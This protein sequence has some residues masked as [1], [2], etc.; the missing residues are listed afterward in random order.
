VL[1]Q[2]RHAKFDEQLLA[3]LGAFLPA[4]IPL[5]LLQSPIFGAD[6]A[7]LYTRKT[8]SSAGKSRASEASPRRLHLIEVRTISR[9]ML[10]VLGASALFGL[11]RSAR[12]EQFV[13]VDAT[14]DYTWDDAMNAKPNKSHFYVNDQNFLNT[15][16]PKNWLAPV[17]Y[18][19]GTLHV[20]TEV[21]K[22]PAGDQQVG[23]TLCYIA[24]VGDYGCADTTYYKTTG[25]FDRETKMTDWW[26][27]DKITWD[28]G[29]K[30]VDLIYAINDSGSGHITNYPELKDLTTPTRVRI[31]MVQVS[32]GSA[33]DP[34]IIQ[35]TSGMGGAGGGGGMG[36]A[37]M[38][39]SMGG[40]AGNASG[41]FGGLLNLAGMEAG[42]SA[43][44]GTPPVTPSAGMSSVAGSGGAPT[45][46][47]ASGG[48]GN[49]PTN[50]APET[51]AG[52]NL[53]GTPAGMAGFGGCLAALSALAL[54]RRT[55]RLL[56]RS[57]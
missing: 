34:S 46:P 53:S 10:V 49:A 54:A 30:Q 16:R 2:L 39:P 24:N 1:L 11:A 57:H 29:I 13:L 25:V 28:Q 55:R 41:G 50:A 20:R 35:T 6:P 12:A 45:T 18:R 27:N 47:T 52:C 21:F 26:Q 4:K 44:A 17:D 15:M 48:V 33:Y 42:G 23:W 51:D 22:K 32:A 40:A 36:G 37:M 38:M 9:K 7:Q 3:R 56:R 43:A 14:F 19:N 5:I 8:C 31:T